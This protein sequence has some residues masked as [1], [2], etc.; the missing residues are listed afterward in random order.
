MFRIPD[1][2]PQAKR[3]ISLLC[4]LQGII[5]VSLV[6]SQEYRG[7]R[8]WDFL[9]S[10]SE[11]A[12]NFKKQVI[13]NCQPLRGCLT[14]CQSILTKL[15]DMRAWRVTWAVGSRT[16]P[17]IIWIR[18]SI[19]WKWKRFTLQCTV[20]C[21]KT[22]FNEQFLVFPHDIIKISIV[23]WFCIVCIYFCV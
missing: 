16:T 19:E 22:R 8:R 10:Q 6:H 4:F 23:H 14:E 20:E 2:L 7:C 13:E 15:K 5:T 11:E 12:R 9:L 17:S 3:S 21:T 1:F 18:K